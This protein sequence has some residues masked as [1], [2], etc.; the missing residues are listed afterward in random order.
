MVK[1]FS[2]G[3]ERRTNSTDDH[4]IGS[5]MP[6]W[7]AGIQI[8]KDASGDFPVDL[9]LGLRC[10]NDDIEAYSPELSQLSVTNSRMGTI[11]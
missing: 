6:A 10:R 2:P 9:G 3:G 7:T 5:V 11:V 8:R 4:D 1:E